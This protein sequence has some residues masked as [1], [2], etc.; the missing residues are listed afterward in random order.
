MSRR[1]VSALLRDAAERSIRY[2]DGVDA[3]PVAPQN[4]EGLAR[5]REPMPAKAGDPAETLRVL[6]EIVAPAT[7]AMAGRRFFG[8]VIGGALPVTVAANCIATAW[9]QNTGLWAPTPGVAT[10][11]EVAL[12]WLVTRSACRRRPARG[13]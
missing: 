6:D 3:R 2:L 10:L 5:L 1:E 11:E 8:F 4:V 13:S 9:D 7:M 12:A